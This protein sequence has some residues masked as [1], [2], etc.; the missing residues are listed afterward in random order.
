MTS[1]EMQELTLLLGISL[2]D[3]GFQCIHRIILQ[4]G[5]MC[6]Q[7]ISTLQLAFCCLFE[8]VSFRTV[9]TE[10]RSDLRS[11]KVSSRFGQRMGTVSQVGVLVGG[12]TVSLAFKKLVGDW[13]QASSEMFIHQPDQRLWM[14][15]FCAFRHG[16]RV[17]CGPPA[18]SYL[19]RGPVAPRTE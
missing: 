4:A 14:W 9:M 7:G 12:G 19:W 10:E 5:N 3:S 2:Y 8:I 18:P 17:S 16:V 11:R 1:S 6:M 13:T 15:C